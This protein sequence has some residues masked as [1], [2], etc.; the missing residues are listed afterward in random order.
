MWT[1]GQRK[2]KDYPDHNTFKVSIEY[3]EES[4]RPEET[5][6]HS[7]LSTKSTVK[8]GVKNSNQIKII[9]ERK[10]AHYVIRLKTRY[11]FTV[12]SNL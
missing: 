6:C 8:T 12:F 11:K 9:N 7:D 5:C 10:D 4:W 2:N 1:G 3:L